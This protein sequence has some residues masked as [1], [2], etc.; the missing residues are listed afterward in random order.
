MLWGT[1]NGVSVR[2]GEGRSGHAV[3]GHG[4]HPRKFLRN[5]AKVRPS[6]K[7]KYGRESETFPP[8][9]PEFWRFA[10]SFPLAEAASSRHT[11]RLPIHPGESMSRRRKWF[12]LELQ[13]HRPPFD[14]LKT[15]PVSG[16]RF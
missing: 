14:R 15:P 6:G 10:R 3:K 16:S 4:T 8:I 5:M 2:H 1:D 7:G 9:F 13:P 12:P 11:P